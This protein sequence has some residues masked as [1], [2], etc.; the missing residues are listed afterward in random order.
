MLQKQEV[1]IARLRD[2]T[3]AVQK[4]K[5][6]LQKK[7]DELADESHQLEVRI[8][9]RDGTLRQRKRQLSVVGN[10][11]VTKGTE[12]AEL[13]TERNDLRR[14]VEQLK[15]QRDRLIRQNETLEQ[16]NEIKP[17]PLTRPID[18]GADA[19]GSIEN[20]KTGTE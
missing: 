9:D 14:E 7:L 19:E 17:T 13:R 6:A 18:P 3:E 16:E 10:D 4:Q 5:R 15:G 1:Q 20:E 2:E 11:I 12:L 8:G